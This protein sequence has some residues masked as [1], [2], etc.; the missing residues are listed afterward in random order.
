[1]LNLWSVQAQRVIA[2]GKQTVEEFVLFEPESSDEVFKEF[3]SLSVMYS[4]PVRCAWLSVSNP[5]SPSFFLSFFFF[6][7]CHMPL[8]MLVLRACTR[9]WCSPT[10]LFCRTIRT[11][12]LGNQ[13]RPLHV[14]RKVT[15]TMK[16]RMRTTSLA[17]RALTQRSTSNKGA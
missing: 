2:G 7:K 5:L 13:T 4:Q 11:T 10:S 1:M 6:C 14:Q 16:M 12:C 8:H 9:V 3:N 17:R 15:M